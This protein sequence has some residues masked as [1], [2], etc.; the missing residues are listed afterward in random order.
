MIY[1]ADGYEKRARTCVDLANETDDPLIQMELLK[2]RQTYLKIVRTLRP[3]IQAAPGS[4]IPR[5]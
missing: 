2:L 1:S 5:A 3:D 4:S